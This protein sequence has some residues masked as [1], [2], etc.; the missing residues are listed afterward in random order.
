[1]SENKKKFGEVAIELGLVTAFEVQEALQR[2]LLLVD[3]Q[4]IGE[5]LCS[6]GLLMPKDVALIIARQMG[7]ELVD[8]AEIEIS[9]NAVHFVDGGLALLYRIVPIALKDR[10]L[11][12][13]G[14]PFRLYNQEQIDGNIGN[15]SRLFDCEVKLV[16]AMPEQIDL[17][18]RE[19]Y[20]SGDDKTKGLSIDERVALLEQQVA[21]LQQLIRKLVAVLRQQAE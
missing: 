18:I 13:A 11:T 20:G 3:Y 1:M 12:V 10:N 9:Q 7:I 15:L 2:Q 17:K 16:Y 6:M 8:L 4:K 5:L 19:L 14:S 21:N